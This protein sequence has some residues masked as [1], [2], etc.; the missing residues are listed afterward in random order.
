[1]G[2]RGRRWVCVL[3]AVAV[4]AACSGGDDDDAG[5]E[6]ETADTAPAP[7]TTV[8]STTVPSTATTTAPATTTSASAPATTRPPTP[9]GQITVDYLAYWAEHDRLAADPAA[10]V[11]VSALAEHASGPA[12][13]SARQAIADLRSQ[14]QRL[15]LGPREKHN[16]YEP[17]VIDTQTAYI[18]DCHVADTR[19]IGADGDVVRS[20]PPGGRLETIAVTL[21]RRADRWLVDSLQYYDLAPGETCSATGPVPG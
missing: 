16:A 7:S 10:D 13:E 1:V 8:P 20:D 15:E 3:C 9:E 11:D 21:V 4:L 18:A 14:G 5:G 17:A 12:L 6:S 19:V 2:E